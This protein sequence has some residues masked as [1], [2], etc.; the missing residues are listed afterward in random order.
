MCAGMRDAW[1]LAWK[2]DM[3]LDGRAEDSLL[4]TYTTVS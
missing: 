2:L 1:N 3:V 4:D